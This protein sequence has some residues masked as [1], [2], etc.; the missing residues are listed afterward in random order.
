MI[1]CCGEALID[2]A[3]TQVPGFGEGFLPHPGGGPYN[4]AIAI[5]RLGAT[6]KF[7]GRLSMDF[8]PTPGE[9]HI[10]PLLP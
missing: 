2:M 7:L 8:C 1:I 10:I 6:V 5:G 9:V 3:R 4:A